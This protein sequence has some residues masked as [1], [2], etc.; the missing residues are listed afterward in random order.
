MREHA[1]ANKVTAIAMPRIGCGL[2]V[3]GDLLLF[4]LFLKNFVFQLSRCCH[5]GFEMV[6]SQKHVESS[7]WQYKNSNHG[8][9]GWSG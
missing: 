9:D 8:T 3:G 7:I 4:S 5:S 2:D 6:S 1:E